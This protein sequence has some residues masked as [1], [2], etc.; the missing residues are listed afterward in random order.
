LARGDE[1]LRVPLLRARVME[2]SVEAGL[3]SPGVAY[4]GI[5]GFREGTAEE[6]AGAARDLGPLRAAVLDV[7]GNPGGRLDESVRVADLFLGEGPAVS[8]RGRAQGSESY[9]THDD[10]ADWSFPLV[11]VIDGQSASAAEILAGVLVDRGR[12][13]LVGAPTFGK[14]SVQSIFGYEDGSALKLTVARYALPSGRGIGD[15]AGLVPDIVVAAG[16]L[17][18]HGLPLAERVQRD[19][20]LRRALAELG[21]PTRR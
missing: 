17:E 20:Q 15:G 12:A 19:P 9:A 10:D 5:R 6:L 14:G 3:A 21:T 16:E 11:V 1:E 8:T 7:R 2:P 4:L 13:K 18:L